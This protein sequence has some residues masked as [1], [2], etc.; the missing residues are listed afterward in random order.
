MEVLGR[1]R[2]DKPSPVHAPPGRNFLP[3]CGPPTAKPAP[4][5]CRSDRHCLDLKARPS[6]PDEPPGAAGRSEH[7]S[8]ERQDRSLSGP[9][10][11]PSPIPTPG[12]V[13]VSADAATTR[14]SL[15]HQR[16]SHSE[17]LSRT[18]GHIEAPVGSASNSEKLIMV[19]ASDR[20][21]SG[22]G[23]NLYH[24]HPSGRGQSSARSSAAR[25][26]RRGRPSEDF[27]D[28]SRVCNAIAAPRTQREA[29]RHDRKRVRSR[30]QPPRLAC[31]AGLKTAFRLST[32]NQTMARCAPPRHSIGSHRSDLIVPFQSQQ[33]NR[34][35][36]EPAQPWSPFGGALPCG[37]GIGAWWRHHSQGSRQRHYSSTSGA[38]A[39]PP[40]SSRRQQREVPILSAQVDAGPHSRLLLPRHHASVGLCVSLTQ[41]V[42]ASILQ[43]SASI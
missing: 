26:A 35:L 9:P 39:V 10:L 24:G 29:A 41:A 11:A 4:A 43:W 38:G 33:T 25:Q 40:R 3:G 20:P 14:S 30:N 42:A 7:H 12:S 18:A 13:G 15:C 17:D 31:V 2:P 32:I 36:I 1:D 21:G 23:V 19:T 8:G 22:P 28:G 6:D 16:R 27:T 37:Q 34:H 5:K